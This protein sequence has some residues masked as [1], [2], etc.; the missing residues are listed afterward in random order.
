MYRC[1]V[2]CLPYEQHRVIHGGANLLRS[3]LQRTWCVNNQ[4]TSENIF[5]YFCANKCSPAVKH[6]VF[7]EIPRQGG[8]YS[9]PLDIAERC[10]GADSIAIATRC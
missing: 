10:F 3:V 4:S 7:S 1:F 8:G 5:G 6:S 9:R 2:D